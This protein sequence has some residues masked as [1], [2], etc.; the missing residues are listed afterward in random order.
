MTLTFVDLN[1]TAPLVPRVSEPTYELIWQR[2]T[3]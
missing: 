1:A 3:K 2:K